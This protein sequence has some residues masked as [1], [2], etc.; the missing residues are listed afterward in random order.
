MANRTNFESSFFR[1][2]VQDSKRLQAKKLIN[3]HRNFNRNFC[4]I[5]KA[6]DHG[7]H[8]MLVQM[9]KLSKSSP[10]LIIHVEFA[11]RKAKQM[12]TKDIITLQVR[13]QS[14]QYWMQLNTVL[15]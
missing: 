14:P 13:D 3:F 11:T 1:A 6:E 9:S 7:P 15:C 4:V 10:K 12:M 8:K 2:K 5:F